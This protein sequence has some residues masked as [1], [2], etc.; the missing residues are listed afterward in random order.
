MVLSWVDER[1][2][3]KWEPPP[4]L[5]TYLCVV[6]MEGLILLLSWIRIK[7][8]ESA[9]LKMTNEWGCWA[10]GGHVGEGLDWVQGNCMTYRCA[11]RLWCWRVALSSTRIGNI[12]C[13]YR[14][15]RSTC[16][17]LYVRTIHVT[18][19]IPYMLDMYKY[20]QPKGKLSSFLPFG[21]K[22]YM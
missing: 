9:G 4:L 14:P 11:T 6:G 22:A 5:N 19:N 16:L 7:G 17:L 15:P 12:V 20:V 13:E 18:L 1:K 10:L 8:L 2:A 21:G 3:A